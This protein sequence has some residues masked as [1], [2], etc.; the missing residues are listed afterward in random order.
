MVAK[1]IMSSWAVVVYD[2]KSDKLCYITL[3]PMSCALLWFELSRVVAC[4]FWLTN[5]GSRFRISI[6]IQAKGLILWLRSHVS[7]W[8]F[9]N[10]MMLCS[11]FD[12]KLRAFG[13]PAPYEV[14]RKR[15]IVMTC[16]AAGILRSGDYL[17]YYERELEHGKIKT[18]TSTTSLEFTHVLIDEAGQ[19]S[20]FIMTLVNTILI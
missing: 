17:R 9:M 4:P 13:L 15:V 18:P 2:I 10:F 11:N 19:V 5:H 16:G 6:Q 1:C 7:D 12:D 14:A 3:S 8:I 20:L